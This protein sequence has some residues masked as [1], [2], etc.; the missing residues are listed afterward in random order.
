VRNSI[1]KCVLLRYDA[2]TNIV[3]RK[4]NKITVI[5]AAEEFD[6]FESYCQEQ[7]FKKSTLIA[8]LVRDHLDSAAHRL[9]RDLPI[10]TGAEKHSK[11]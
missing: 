5:L 8:R 7:G 1:E 11:S 2:D 9:Q 3:A 4:N 10:R 6:R